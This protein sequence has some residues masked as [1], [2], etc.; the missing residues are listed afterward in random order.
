MRPLSDPDF[1]AGLL[2]IIFGLVAVVAAGENELGTLSRMGPAYFPTLAGGLLTGLG[3]L[4]SIRAVIAPEKHVNGPAMQWGVLLFILG[5][6]AVFALAL[7]YLGLIAAVILLVLTAS[8]ANS[9]A[10]PIEALILSVVLSVAAWLIFI[11]GLGLHIALW[12]AGY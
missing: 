11:E 6:V 7:I 12:P 4:V 9:A 10:R 8:F 5:S 2:F 1:W 3:A